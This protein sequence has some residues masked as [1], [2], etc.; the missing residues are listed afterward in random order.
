[1]T[2]PPSPT[3]TP[4]AAIKPNEHT[5][6]ARTTHEH[7]N[8]THLPHKP[9]TTPHPPMPSTP[10][11]PSPPPF[12]PTPRHPTPTR[13]MCQLRPSYDH[14]TNSTPLRYKSPLPRYE[15]CRMPLSACRAHPLNIPRPIP[16]RNPP[17]LPAPATYRCGTFCP[18]TSQLRQWDTRR[19]SGGGQRHLGPVLVTWDTASQSKAS[20]TSGPN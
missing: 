16:R 18:N 15:E 6:Y 11:N 9:S 1:M 20:S 5:F 4:S 19:C 2:F 17:S 12:P 7:P 13:H 8:P 3:P 10:R 14:S